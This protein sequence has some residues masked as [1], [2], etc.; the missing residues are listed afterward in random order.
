MQNYN[1]LLV[2][3]KAHD[4]TPIIYAVEATFLKEKK[5]TA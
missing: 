4:F 2:W 1:N 3:R 5:L